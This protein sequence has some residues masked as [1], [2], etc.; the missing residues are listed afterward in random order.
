MNEVV[1]WSDVRGVNWEILAEVYRRAPLGTP[2]PERLRRS[3]TNSDVCCFAFRRGELV[4]AGRAISDGEA[5]ATVCELVVAPDFQRQ[6]IGSAI[7]RSILAQLAVPKVILA[8]VHGQEEFYR[9]EGFL[10]HKSVMALYENS[11]WFVA[12]GYL[13]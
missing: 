5:F 11:E 10:K 4:G 9:K 6:G 2:D 1:I 3:Y 7:L 13:E 12:N 8:C